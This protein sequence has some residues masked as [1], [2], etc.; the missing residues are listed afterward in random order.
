MSEKE[1][2]QTLELESTDEEISLTL[3]PV[4]AAA[5]MMKKEEEPE[6]KPEI[7]EEELKQV[8]YDESSLTESEKKMVEEF[9]KKIDITDTTTILQYGANAQT[10]VADFSEN[11][12]KNVKTQDLGD[13]GGLMTDLV[14][15][16]KGFEINKE[17]NFFE[18]LFKKGAN[19]ATAM[20]AKYDDAEKN[21]EKIAK[22]LEGHQ[23]TLLKDIALLDQLYEKNLVNFKEISMYILAGQKKLEEV[24]T[25]D[26]VA[27][28]EKAKATGLPE[29][30]QAV[31]DLN[32]A[33]NRFE[34]KL[35][36]LELTRMVSLQM[37]PQIRLV[38][39]N[40]T[41][42][43]EKIQSVL[44]NT[45]PLWKSQMLIALGLHHSQ[46]AIKAENAVTE[47]TNQMLRENAE[48]LHIATVETAEA[49]ERG[50]VDL[51][52]LTETNKKL[53]QTLE[54]VAQIQKDGREKRAAAQLEL[55]KMEIELSKRLTEIQ[56]ELENKKR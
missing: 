29:D 17:D 48:N 53:I 44:V 14:G 4:G 35:H 20:K 6:A 37:A 19:K 42:M 27:L 10:K 12:L 5:E 54:E 43:T 3:D 15:Q 41:L 47:M 45:I 32:N 30:A 2:K 28:Q 21:V 9:S 49:S 31:N 39:N 50:I 55:R 23:I 52:T 18:K 56:G 8:K 36:D 51:E 25:K 1:A 40:D 11:A 7:S 33:I 24:K 13:I 38:Q 34:K 16:L 22:V 26:L 46:E